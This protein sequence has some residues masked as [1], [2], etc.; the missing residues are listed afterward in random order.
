MFAVLKE[1]LRAA[2]LKQCNVSR[3][4]GGEGVSGADV[5]MDGIDI[6][7]TLRQGRAWSGHG[8]AEG[9]FLEQKGVEKRRMEEE[10][11]RQERQVT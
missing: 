8:P 3:V 6:A 5:Q 10:E 11:Q 4:E 1:D 7:E 9:Q 2:L